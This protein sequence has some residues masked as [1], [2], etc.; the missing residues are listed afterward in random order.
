MRPD[1]IDQVPARGAE[2]ERG[3]RVRDDSLDLQPMPDDGRIREQTLDICRAE[4]RHGL[5]VEVRERP[6]KRFAL[7]EDRQPGKPRLEP[8]ETELLEQA[9]LVGDRASPL[10]VVIV[11]VD[12]D[13]V[14]EAPPRRIQNDSPV[15]WAVYGPRPVSTAAPHLAASATASSGPSPRAR[16]KA[17]PAAKL[18]PQP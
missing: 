6:A 3:P 10:A 2:L 14:A 12:L 8:L 9:A 11:A 5:G 1:N 15:S 18:S 7:A 17:K 13:V 16:A 4:L